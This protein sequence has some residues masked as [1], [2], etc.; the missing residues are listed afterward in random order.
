MTRYFISAP[1]KQDLKDIKKFIAR[2]NPVAATGFV[3]KFRRVCKLLAK[4]PEMGSSSENF[5]PSLRG[6]PLESYIIF[7]RPIKNGINVE[8]IVSGYR[9]LEAI[10]VPDDEDS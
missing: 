2:S 3:E 9:D 7:Y 6:F 8:R 5:A 10:F 1:A 4:F